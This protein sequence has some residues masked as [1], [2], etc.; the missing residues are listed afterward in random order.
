MVE[1]PSFLFSPRNPLLLNLILANFAPRLL[2]WKWTSHNLLCGSWLAVQI[3]GLGPWLA[4]ALFSVHR[5]CLTSRIYLP[6]RRTCASSHERTINA[7]SL[8]LFP[9]TF[10]R[11]F[12]SRG[13]PGKT[14]GILKGW[15]ATGEPKTEKPI[16]STKRLW[17]RCVSRYG[18][19]VGVVSQCQYLTACSRYCEHIGITA[20]PHLLES[21]RG[22]F[23]AWIDWYSV[24]P[25]EDAR[26]H[27]A[28]GGG[29]T[30]ERS[31]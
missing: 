7:A 24:Q 3:M 12:T 15:L 10:D 1:P 29:L 31:Q 28:A 25:K 26:N 8:S 19:F 30:T 20:G 17:D 6:S 18:T 13:K 23:E 9:S 16:S 22:E 21:G 5:P 27:Q 11:S 4:F 14:R 2:L